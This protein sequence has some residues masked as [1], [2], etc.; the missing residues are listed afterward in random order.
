MN[1]VEHGIGVG[2][3]LSPCAFKL[4]GYTCDYRYTVSGGYIYLEKTVR[5][6]A[7]PDQTWVVNIH[8]VP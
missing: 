5:S 2:F 3:M 4:D 7:Q 6:T 8:S 1:I